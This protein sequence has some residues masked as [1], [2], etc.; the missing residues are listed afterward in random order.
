MT[1]KHISQ[2][3]QYVCISKRKRMQTHSSKME[4]AA[5]L[6]GFSRQKVKKIRKQLTCNS[7]TN[8]FF[9][10]IPVFLVIYSSILLTQANYSHT[11]KVLCKANKQRDS[12]S[13][14]L[15]P[16]H[17]VVTDSIFPTKHSSKTHSILSLCHTADFCIRAPVWYHIRALLFVCH[18]QP[19]SCPV[20]HFTICIAADRALC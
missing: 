20:V 17:G 8:I 4:H 2:T 15:Q 5:P 12:L 6:K 11:W 7:C 1:S 13:S 18:R 16:Q 3:M 19:N 14:L 9:V 10:F